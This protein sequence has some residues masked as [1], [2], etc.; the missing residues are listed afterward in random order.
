MVSKKVRDSLPFKLFCLWKAS[1]GDLDGPYAYA[2]VLE[3]MSFAE[4]TST[5]SDDE[6]SKPL[7]TNE[8]KKLPEKHLKL[9][10]SLLKAFKLMNEELIKLHPKINALES[11]TTAVTLIKQVV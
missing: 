1:I 4:I 11:G 2:S 9:K 6:W 5:S 10:H 8:L 3:R 7:D